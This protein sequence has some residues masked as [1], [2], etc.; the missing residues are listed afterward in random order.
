MMTKMKP[1]MNKPKTLSENIGDVI[2]SLDSFTSNRAGINACAVADT[3]GHLCGLIASNR[4]QCSYGTRFHDEVLDLT[5]VLKELV[6]DPQEIIPQ[7][8]DAFPS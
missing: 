8:P 2:D 5:R 1:K 3:I 7:S 4:Y 6:R